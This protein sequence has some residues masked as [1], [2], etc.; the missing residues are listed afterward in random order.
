MSNAILKISGRKKTEPVLFIFHN[1]GHCESKPVLPMKK[2]YYEL[3]IEQKKLPE[4]QPE[5]IIEKYY[6]NAE[7]MNDVINCKFYELKLL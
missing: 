7:I 5:K 1:G 6:K 4:I 2:K 3:L